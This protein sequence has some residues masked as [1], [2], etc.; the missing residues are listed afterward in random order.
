MYYL[1]ILGLVA[2]FLTTMAYV[3]QVIKALKTK[4]MKDLSMLWLLT[5]EFG[6]YYGLSMDFS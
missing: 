4:S 1:V 6:A 5:A 3:P 2:G